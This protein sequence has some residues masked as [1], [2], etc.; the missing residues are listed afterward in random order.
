MCDKY[1][2]HIMTQTYTK[3][4]IKKIRNPTVVKSFSP[5]KSNQLHSSEWNNS[6]FE[7]NIR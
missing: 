4:D 5:I 2:N 1:K 3:L 6:C 7:T